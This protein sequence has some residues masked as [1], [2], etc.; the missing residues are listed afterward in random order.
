MVTIPRPISGS[1]GSRI[2]VVLG[3]EGD[4]W[5]LI[6]NYD[7]GNRKWQQFLSRGIPKAVSKQI[8]NCKAKNRIVTAVD[9]GPDGAWYIHGEKFDG[10]AG[11]AWWGGTTAELKGREV[12]DVSFGTTESGDKT[13]VFLEGSYDYAV[14][15]NN[16]NINDRLLKTHN[17]KKKINFVRLFSD[18]QYVISD[19]E[20]IAWKLEG[21]H[22]KDELN[23]CNRK[24]ELMDVALSKDGSWVIIRDNSFDTSSGV[25]EAL[26]SALTNF[27]SKQ[28]GYCNQRSRE[29]REAKRLQREAA[30]QEEREAAELSAVTRIST[31]EAAIEKRLIEEA[32]DIKESE[33]KLQT[34][35]RALH[36][37]IQYMPRESRARITLDDNTIT[38]SNDSNHNVCVICHENVS[39]MAVIPCGHVCLCNQCSDL[40]T[41]SENGQQSC[42]LCRG[43]MQSVLRIY[44]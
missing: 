42:P 2:R 8:N 32:K 26:R 44:L 29:I 22:I 18:G 15:H 14:F 9:F 1:I 24:G 17:R 35:K 3:N 13:Y 37:T 10:T 21:E 4:E 38:S 23:R 43:N 31:L 41:N 36:D 39:S 6:M 28:R 27:Y 33:E 5:L 25:D 16:A 19:H 40:C 30:E 34:R 11:H 12:R 20:G 7:D